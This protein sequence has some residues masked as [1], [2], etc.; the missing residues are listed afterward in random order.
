MRNTPIALDSGA[1]LR[2]T[3]EVARF[4][5]FG[6]IIFF[7]YLLKTSENFFFSDIFSGA[8]RDLWLFHGLTELG[9]IRNNAETM[10][11]KRNT[12]FSFETLNYETYFFVLHITLF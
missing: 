12:F 4:N 8:E 3:F 10:L 9:K 7:L 11:K 1:K 5:S 2:G 6:A